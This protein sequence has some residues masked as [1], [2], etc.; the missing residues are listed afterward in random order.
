MISSS[1]FRRHAAF[2]RA[3]VAKSTF[4]IRLPLMGQL[5]LLMAKRSFWV[6]DGQTTFCG[7]VSASP[8]LP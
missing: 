2:G 6:F 4:A 1:F 7:V 8:C 3:G 5:E